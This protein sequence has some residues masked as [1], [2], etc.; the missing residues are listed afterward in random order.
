MNKPFRGSDTVDHPGRGVRVPGAPFD[1]DYS[2]AVT[3]HFSQDCHVYSCGYATRGVQEISD[4]Q[5]W[6]EGKFQDQ[7]RSQGLPALFRSPAG[8]R[9][10]DYHT[11]AKHEGLQGVKDP[12]GP[13]GRTAT[14]TPRGPDQVN[15]ISSVMSIFMWRFNAK[16]K[17]LW[18]FIFTLNGF[19]KIRHL[20]NHTKPNPFTS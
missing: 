19:C 14:R 11:S 15:V 1:P 20:V 13:A 9:Q 17:T 10:R 4:N 7:G 3:T 12:R 18:Q 16:H 2:P 8:L 6:Q 5:E